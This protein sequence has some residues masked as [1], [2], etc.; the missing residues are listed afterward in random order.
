MCFLFDCER[1]IL[2]CNI[3]SIVKDEEM[4]A[5]SLQRSDNLFQ[6]TQR[7]N[8]RVEMG[9]TFQWWKRP[10]RRVGCGQQKGLRSLEQPGGRGAHVPYLE[11]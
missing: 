9:S 3:I 7:V 10:E 11:S 1:L 5:Y 2:N 4:E 6:V 8:V